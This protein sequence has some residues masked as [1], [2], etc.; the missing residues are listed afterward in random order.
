MEECP[1]IPKSLLEKGGAFMREKKRRK[2]LI[3]YSIGILIIIYYVFNMVSY[4]SDTSTVFLTS[5]HEETDKEEE[6]EITV[7]I[8]NG[9]TAAFNFFLYFDESKLE[10]V[11][12]PENT[13]VIGNRIVF[14][15]YDVEGGKGAKEGE[16]AKFKFKAKENGLATFSLQGEFY[17]EIGQFMQTDTKETQI[18]IGKEQTDLQRQ[19]EGEQGTDT[20]SNNATLQV[21][22]LD[23]EGLIPSFEKN[24]H[25]YYLTVPS[26]VPEIEVLAI[27][28]NPNATI[29]IMGNTGLKEGLNLIT[30]RVTSADKTQNNVYTIQVTKTANIE[31]ANTNLEILAIENVLLN[32]PFDVNETNYK[33]EISNETENINLLAVQENE[34]AT[35]EV[36]GKDNLVEGKNLVSVI[37]TAPNGFTKKKYQV[38]VYKR[39]AEEEAKFLEEQNLKKEMLDHAYEIA[40]LSAT[41]EEKQGEESKKENDKNNLAIVS[42][43]IGFGIVVLIGI[44]FYLRYKKS[45]LK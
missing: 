32:P 43:A 17:N 29:E 40:D 11:G 31:L 23:K 27:G 41:G 19:V 1:L 18:Q 6:L 24:V 35:V 14:V 25:E 45:N 38:E 26:N 39:N 15:W 9:K 22:R 10:Y 8:E 16:L 37:V 44:F 42:I 13:N 34:Q 3:S 7:H 20:Q 2:I 12:G 4:A 36:I 21:L 5:N 30:V 28:E 33:V